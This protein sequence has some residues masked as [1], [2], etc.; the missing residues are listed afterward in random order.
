M[1]LPV[2]KHPVLTMQGK[3][4]SYRILAES[5]VVCCGLLVLALLKHDL[6][7]THVFDLGLYEQWVSLA[8]QNRWSEV[9]SLY[10]G[11]TRTK[12]LFFGDHSS[13]ILWPIG[14]LY[15]IWPSSGL[16]ISLQEIGMSIGYAL[17]LYYGSISGISQRRLLLLRM[18]I[19]LNPIFY[20]S[21]LDLFSLESIAFP[22][23]VGSLILF[24]RNRLMPAF[25]LVLVALLTK[26][27]VAAWCFG[28]ALYLW[29]IK[30]HRCGLWL[31]IMSIAIGSFLYLLNTGNHDKLSERLL[32]PE[33][34]NS[35]SHLD[36]STFSVSSFQTHLLSSAPNSILI[37]VLTVAGF[38]VVFSSKALI[39]SIAGMLPS[40]I[41][42]IASDAE[43]MRSFI[44]HYQL[45]ILM[46]IIVGIVDTRVYTVLERIG[47]GWKVSA[48]VLS[49][50]A[51]T[52]FLTLSQ[53]KDPFTSWWSK[54][55]YVSNARN[56]STIVRNLATDRGV[57]IYT[58]GDLATRFAAYDHVYWSGNDEWFSKGKASLIVLKKE[59]DRDL[60]KEPLW[61]KI[62]NK[63][64]S[65]GHQD[66]DGSD[67]DQ[68]FESLNIKDYDCS[69]T[70]SESTI[71][72]CTKKSAR[73][74]S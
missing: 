45:P 56:I 33:R 39:P 55:Q 66:T 60:L 42:N 11:F 25:V 17:L 49:S 28:L 13:V 53:F 73:D 72:I 7:Q 36:I 21:A 40:L 32:T 26:E 63:L 35:L 57:L 18:L 50:I 37:Y 71:G 2:C 15:K 9:G 29:C 54:S 64:F 62:C 58:S 65:Y 48:I 51:I 22:L 46:W 24:R 34:M 19:L 43:T 68:F 5:I 3:L 30:K 8:S 74:Y 6:L 52:G 10:L 27:L 31:G 67:F 12:T 16:L 4:P 1:A 38:L 20:N 14:L 61:R 47:S 44:Y 69:H 23:L 59:I 41:I 70:S